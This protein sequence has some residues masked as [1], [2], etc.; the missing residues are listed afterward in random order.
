MTD[1]LRALIAAIE[2]VCAQHQRKN[3]GFRD[4]NR[5]RSHSS[6]TSAR[7]SPRPRRTTARERHLPVLPPC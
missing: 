2:A 6:P 7:N 1:E 5:S 4:A 3:A